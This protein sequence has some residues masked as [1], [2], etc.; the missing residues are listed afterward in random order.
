MA[1]S[2]ALS[3]ETERRLEAFLTD[4]LTDYRIPGVGLAI[5]KDDE[6]VYAAGLGARDLASNEPATPSTRYGVASITKSFTA[7]AVLQ[8]VEEGQVD[9]DAPVTAYV[10]FFDE[11]A[12]PPRVHELL[13][14][15]SGMPSDGASVALISR[16]IGAEPVEVPLSSDAD[17]ERYVRDAGPERALDDRFFYYNT[18][19]TILGRVVEA[20]DG[21]DFSTYVGQEILDP[22]GMEQSV[23]APDEF[24]GL[25]DAMTPYR[26]E[27]GE[28][29]KAEFPVKGVGAAGGLVSTARDLAAYLRFQFD[30][31]PAVLDP[32]LLRE[33]RQAHVTRQRYLDN[34]EQGYGYGWMRR[35]FL[36]DKLVEHGGSLAVSTAYVGFLEETALGIAIA[37]N[38]S[39]EAHP[40]HVGRALL[41]IIDGTD[42]R[43]ASHF[44]G[45]RAA[46]ER[47]SGD[48]S[49][50]RD[51]QRAAVERD[52]GGLEIRFENALESKT[53]AAVPEN[54]DPDDLRYY[55]IDADGVRIPI[56]FEETADGLDMFYRRWRL[57]LD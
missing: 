45:L 35:P 51:I 24:E 17:L 11:M 9:L 4:W 7:L 31:D 13:T 3:A 14:H 32:A 29:V 5:V 10:P 50:Y 6:V 22:I 18:G 30:P 57:H 23:L 20:V 15:N 39:P 26:E 37:C 52:G 36:E 16:A 19:Y 56:E 43:E 8:L 21:R 46:A 33:A 48:Y 34:T 1:R 40:S 42:P 49:S 55:S 2:T 54:A 44:F 47:V 38:D 53:I 25:E 27:N 12:D 28:R 41:A